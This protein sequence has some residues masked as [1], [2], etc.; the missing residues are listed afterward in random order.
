[1]PA[2]DPIEVYDTCVAAVADPAIRQT[3]IVNQ[4]HMVRAVAAF[5]AATI[6]TSWNS[7]PRTARGN[8]S[9]IIIGSLTKKNLMDLYSTYMVDATGPSRDVYDDILVAAGGL[10]PFCGGLGQVYTL[11]HYLPKSS[12]P[13]YSILPANLVP[14]CRDCNTSKGPTFGTQLDEQTLHPY[15]DNNKYFEQ[16][17]LSAQVSKTNPIVVSFAC[18]PP[19]GWSDTDKRR[20][21]RHFESYKFAYRFSIQAGGDVARLMDL[22]SKSLQALHPA[23]F[24]EYLL[25]NA[26]T[27]GFDLNGWSRT[28]YTALAETAWFLEADFTNP[29]WHLL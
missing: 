4:A 16:R 24:K 19:T 6:A 13:A 1:M 25:D 22:R 29:S 27:D 15:L 26:R 17:W 7:L 21:R 20:V 10:C 12:F 28:M 8:P 14:C 3:Y 11:D 2:N 18:S 5:D 9:A 23:A